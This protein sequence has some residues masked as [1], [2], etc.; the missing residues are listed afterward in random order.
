MLDRLGHAARGQLVAQL[1]E[2]RR[3]AR[4]A[5]RS[6]RPRAEGRRAQL[7]VARRQRREPQVGDAVR[8]MLAGARGLAALELGV[9]RQHARATPRAGCRA[10]D[11]RAGVGEQEPRPL[12]VVRE[13]VG[14]AVGPAR[15]ELRRE[16]RLERLHRRARLEPGRAAGER[17]A[18]DASTTAA[19][20]RSRSARPARRARGSNA[21]PR[22]DPGSRSPT[23]SAAERRRTRTRPRARRD[24]QRL[25]VQVREPDP[26]RSESRST[27]RYRGRHSGKNFLLN[28]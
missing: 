23:R 25:D 21:R 12:L 14:D 8:E 10:P 2:A 26:G 11:R 16:P 27:Q 9:A 28:E 1:G 17:H 4:R 6:R 5:G 20:A 24:E 15:R 18:Q 19:R 7:L 22:R 3:E 13:H